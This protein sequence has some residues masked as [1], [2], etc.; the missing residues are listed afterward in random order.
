MRPKHSSLPD[1]QV[2]STCREDIPKII[3]LCRK[4]YASAPPWDSDQ[5]ES[6]LH[7]FPEGQL[8]A[9]APERDE[10]VGMASS[11]IVAWDDYDVKQTW[12]DFTDRGY[13]KNHDPAGRTLYGAEVM[14][15]PTL[16]GRGIGKKIYAARRAITRQLKLRRI[17]AGARLRGYGKY[18]DQMSP[19]DY[20]KKVIA[21][22]IGDPTL[23]FQIKQG[24]RVIAVARHYLQHDPA[25]Q[26]HAAVIE[27]INHEVAQRTDYKGRP[28]EF[29]K[30]RKRN[31]GLS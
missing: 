4:V 23:T 24:F 22:E 20:V 16:Q 31:D 30:H 14:V 3:E 10:V 25:S 26:G 28:A 8:V 2:R 29:A 6:H 7:Y 1:I 27:W 21:R 12:A 18:A 17:R 9:V 19:E 15:D 11:L 13:F 5:L